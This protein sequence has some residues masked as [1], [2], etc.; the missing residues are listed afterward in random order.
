MKAINTL[1]LIFSITFLYSQEEITTEQWLADI[2]FLQEKVHQ[3]Y[4]FLFKKINGEE[5]NQLVEDLKTNLP[6][7]DEH[8]IANWYCQTYFSFSLWSH[9]S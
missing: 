6:K 7:L 3:D 1:L 8:E 9:Q 4:P 2:E 5:W